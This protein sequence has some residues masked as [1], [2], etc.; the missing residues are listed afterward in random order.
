[1]ANKVKQMSVFCADCGCS[2]EYSPNEYCCHCGG[3]WEFEATVPMDPLDII[4]DEPSLWRYQKWLEPVVHV[5]QVSLGEGWT[6]L[7]PIIIN[8]HKVFVKPEFYG[9][10][11]SFKDRGVSVMINDLLNQSIKH[12]IEDSSGNAGAAVAA[13][14]ARAGIEADIFVPAH[15]SPAKLA[16][17]QV[18]GA[19]VRTIEG[20]RV[21]AKRAALRAVETENKTL[22]SHAYHPAYLLGQQTA[23]WEA[24]EQLGRQVPDW[25]IVPVGQGGLLLGVWLAF[26][27]L[28]SAGIIKN[29]P[30]IVAAQPALFAPVCQAYEQHL[31][32]VPELR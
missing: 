28:Y 6:P 21:N 31:D 13:Y 14:A 24:W 10:T 1:M 32:T 11:G 7:L 9:P 30:R 18:Y 17:I 23:G 8:D 25:V 27:R 19:N 12:I 22:A 15:A 29:V 16:Q 20:P 3:A 26:E 2:Q 4:T 5:P